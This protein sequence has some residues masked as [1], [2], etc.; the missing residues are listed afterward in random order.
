MAYCTVSELRTY[1]GDNTTIDESLLGDCIEAAEAEINTLCG[2]YFSQDT[3]TSSRVFEPTVAYWAAVDDISTTSGPVIAVGTGDGTFGTTWTT[4]DY[5]LEP[6]NGIQD[7]I[8]GW[9]YTKIRAVGGLT[10]P[11]SFSG[12]PVLQV[13]AK[14]G[15]AAVPAPI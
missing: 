8:S 3:A 14:W 12:R 4:D 15:W 2:R 13:T 10:F 7:G 1:L 11:C 6:L 5:Q 9:P